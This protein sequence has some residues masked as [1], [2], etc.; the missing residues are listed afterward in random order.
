MT[1]AI[2]LSV[3]AKA[4][5]RASK[6]PFA[7]ALILAKDC[8][9]D[10]EAASDPLTAEAK[11]ATEEERLFNRSVD[12]SSALLKFT[13]DALKPPTTEKLAAPSTAAVVDT[14]A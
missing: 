14:L 1:K 5:P 11:S 8:A 9:T 13:S 12:A 2:A 3:R 4:V 6:R 10:C 7:D